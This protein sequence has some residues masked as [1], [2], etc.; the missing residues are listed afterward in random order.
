LGFRKFSLNCVKN[1]LNK[2][3]ASFSCAGK[4]HFDFGAEKSHSI[5]PSE[6]TCSYCEILVQSCI[7]GERLRIGFVPEF[8]SCLP[9]SP[10]SDSQKGCWT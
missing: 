10:G 9:R 2:M 8:Y 7:V 6:G 4:G 3:E 1:R 5:S